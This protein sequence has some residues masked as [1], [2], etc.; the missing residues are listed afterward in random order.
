MAG[1]VGE[2]CDSLSGLFLEGEVRCK[3]DDFSQ[4]SYLLCIPGYTQPQRLSNASITLR[5]FTSVSP[6]LTE[7]RLI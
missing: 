3:W 7:Q 1:R 2:V 5:S 4:I 6:S